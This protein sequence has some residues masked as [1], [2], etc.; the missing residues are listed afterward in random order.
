MRYALSVAAA[1]C[2]GS[3]CLGETASAQYRSGPAVL[4]QPPQ[5][6]V[7]APAN[8]TLGAFAQ[9]NRAVGA[10]P[11]VVFWN[12]ALTDQASTEYTETSDETDER[13]WSG[14]KTGERTTTRFGE[15]TKENDDGSERHVITRES[16]RRVT[17]GGLHSQIDK[18]ASSLYETVFLNAFLNTG[19]RLIDR[20]TLIR[21]LSIS[22]ADRK[23]LQH[24][25][26]AALGAG[27][28]YL[29]EVLPDPAPAA[30]TGIKFTV[31][32]RHLPTSSLRAQFIT[33]AEPPKG[34]SRF[35]ATSDGFVRQ[36]SDRNTPERVAAQL[37]T[38]TMA[39]LIAR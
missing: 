13:R 34:N 8:A 21:K 17:T 10:P 11:M 36:Q 30:S 18:S 3:L 7:D 35:V 19:A 39:R 23:D 2:L 4:S 37:A 6:D 25:E 28:Q 5:T 32:I 24:L 38:E 1:A 9:W 12:R 26:S 15:A 16:G 29:I 33:I 31:K 27:I 20:E 22:A 14:S